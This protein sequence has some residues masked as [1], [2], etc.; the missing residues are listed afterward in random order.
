MKRI[1]LIIILFSSYSFA[2]ERIAKYILDGDLVIYSPNISQGTLLWNTIVKKTSGVE[3]NNITDRLDFRIKQKMSANMFTQKGASELGID[4][5]GGMAFVQL[6]SGVSYVVFTLDNESLLRSRLDMLST[7]IPYR[8][9]ENF[10][11]FSSS[12]DIL[13]FFEFKGITMLPEFNKIAKEIN[14][15]WNKNLLWID[16]AAFLR[17]TESSFL[18]MGDRVVGTFNVREDRM[19]LDTITLYDDPEISQ[20]IINSM[21]VEPTQKMTLLDFE[22]G[23]PGLVG[24]TYV[25][26]QEFYSLIK[27]IDRADYLYFVSLIDG[28][29]KYGVDLDNDVF[30]HL[31]GR[32]SYAV[33]A[34]DIDKKAF[35][36]NLSVETKNENVLREN[37]RKIVRFSES[38]GMKV[39]Y[40]DLFTR[41]F[42]GWDIQG[43]TVWLGIVENHLIVSSDEDNLVHFVQNIYQDKSGFLAKLPTSMNRLIKNQTIG[44]QVVLTNPHFVQNFS[45]L[46]MFVNREFMLALTKAEWDY[47]LINNSN[48]TGRRDIIILDFNK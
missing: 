33:R 13:D 14:L 4:Y 12:Q 11:I 34:F 41:Q 9:E 6:N 40:K 25:N 15:T 45:L 47:Y 5:F 8:I 18:S 21:K 1:L 19:I 35:D 48:I 31:K 27:K 38:K 36:F 7:P 22:F 29:N 2:K 10:V 26:Y 16:S 43:V 46:S 30:K 28:I 37:I 3:Y 20:S 32:L 17:N 44:G 42:F 23:T 24:H 39:H